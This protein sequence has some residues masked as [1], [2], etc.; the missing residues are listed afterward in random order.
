MVKEVSHFFFFLTN[1]EKIIITKE[2]RVKSDFWNP[3]DQSY[4]DII[5]WTTQMDC[6]KVSLFFKDNEFG[7]FVMVLK[8]GM[9]KELEE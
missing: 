4:R 8:I 2:T 3:R 6:I 7:T 1:K 5:Y 9:V